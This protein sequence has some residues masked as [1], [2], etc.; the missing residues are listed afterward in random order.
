[1]MT[2]SLTGVEWPAFEAGRM[3]AEM[4]IERLT[5]QNPPLRQHLIAAELVVRESTGPAPRSQTA[6]SPIRTRRN[7]TAG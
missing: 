3:A 4:L 2:P 1:M 5:V 6:V 7:R